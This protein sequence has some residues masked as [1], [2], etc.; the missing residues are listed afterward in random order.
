MRLLARGFGIVWRSP[1]LLLLGLVPGVISA[2]IVLSGFAVL[3]YFIK[4]ISA[5]ATWFADDWSAG[6]RQ[7]ARLV[8]G[9]AIVVVSGFVAV[10]AFTALTLTIGDPFYEV[11]SA[12][13]DARYGGAPDEVDAPWYRTIGSSLADS[14]RL[15]AM[16][17]GVGAVL[18]L[19]GFIPLLGQTVIPALEVALGGWFVAVEIS[20]V[21]FGRRG[22]R[23]RQYRQLL[24]GHRALALGFGVPVFLLFLIP[25]AAIVVMPG[26]VAGAT[27]LAR[28]ILNQP[29]T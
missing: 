5:L 3:L 2:V 27:L 12:R 17:L 16:T 15:I 6:A 1:R 28:R 14:G 23:L 11:I 9:I 4:D 19:A 18:F 21:A 26:A 25:L 10:L 24:R 29:H 20:G 7:F 13:V 22:Y 8:A